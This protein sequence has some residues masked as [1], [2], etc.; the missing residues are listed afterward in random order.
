MAGDLEKMTTEIEAAS[1]DQVKIKAIGDKFKAQA[2]G[3]KSEGEALRKLLTEAENKELERYAKE[4]IAP[5]TDRLLAAMMKAQAAAQATAPAAAAQ[6]A[7]PAEEAPKIEVEPATDPGIAVCKDDASG[8]FGRILERLDRECDKKTEIQRKAFR[9]QKEQEFAAAGYCGKISG[10]VRDV[11][12]GFHMGC[13]APEGRGAYIS[14]ENIDGVTFRN[15][16][17]FFPEEELSNYQN[18]NKGDKMTLD[19]VA[20]GVDLVLNGYICGVPR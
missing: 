20:Y 7:A 14:L 11:G 4:K 3:M 1:S 15:A 13:K 8:K 2:E 19:I 17:V 9:E 18:V 5:L 6:P 12:S 10:R 16:Q